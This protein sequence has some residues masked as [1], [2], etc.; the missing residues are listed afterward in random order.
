MLEIAIYGKGGIGK[1]TMAANISSA[2]SLNNHRVL[3]IGCDPKHDSTRLL[4]HGYEVTTVLDY[5]KETNPTQYQK[6][7]ILTYGYNQIGCI[8]AGGPT[9][10]VGCAGRGIITTFE[11]LDNLNIKSEFDITV[12]DVLGD[13]VCGVFAVPIRNEYADVIF[14]VT[15]GE[16]M[17]LYAANNILRGI[18][19][20]DKSKNRVA[21]IIFNK[22]N[23][24]DEDTRLQAFAKAVDLPIIATI[25][26]S[27]VFAKADE[28]NQTVVEIGLDKDID[29]VFA[30]LANKID[31]GLDLYKAKPVSDLELEQLIFKKLK[32]IPK[33]KKEVITNQKQQSP[34]SQNNPNFKYLSKN[35]VSNE[36]LHGCAFNGA[37][38]MAVH[39]QDVM[40]IAHSPK[41][42]TFISYQTISSSGRRGLFERGALLPVS[43]APKSRIN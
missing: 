42:C 29:H 11:L 17:S 22:R 16:Y 36:P 38:S 41:N 27:D 2:L 32:T 37:I 28:A 40:I 39:L 1:S 6:E 12:Y 5:I 25:P 18:E 35:M 21:G 20:Y 34:Q 8:E 26:R 15:S 30:K 9:P 7:D 19:N 4:T 33:T 31:Q 23:I 13:V 43:I 3:Q 14:I 10:G 24:V